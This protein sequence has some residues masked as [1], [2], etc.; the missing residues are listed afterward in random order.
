M[1]IKFTTLQLHHITRISLFLF[2]VIIIVAL[3]PKEN[4]FQ[5]QFEVGKPWT[6]GLMTASYDFPIYKSDMQIT[7]EKEQ[8]LKDYTP[9]YKLDTNVVDVQVNRM[10]A[11]W[12]KTHGSQPAFR[13]FIRNKFKAIYS[14][15]I[16][17]ID[18]YNKLLKE[19]RENISRIMPN[20]VTNTLPTA[21]LYTP[22]TAYEAIISDA[23]EG[24]KS[25]NLNVYL[26]ENLKFD[27]STSA[28]SKADMLKNLSLTSGMVQ[29]GER[30]IDRGEIVN[31]IN[32]QV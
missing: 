27:S 30:I 20:R 12:N 2:A 16:V 17:S 31:P 9:F 3:F 10:I 13:D 4:K 26:V 25:S 14:V 11:D 24:L 7:R 22:R 32:F 21:S 29:S 8:I 19:K 1:K 15:G 5:Y 18:E 28:L 6:Y 23:P